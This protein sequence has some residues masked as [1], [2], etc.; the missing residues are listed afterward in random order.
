MSL[1]ILRAA[2]R[3]ASP[4]KNGGG[5]TREIAA[6]PPGASLAHFTWRISTATVEAGGPFSTFPGVDRTLAILSGSLDLRIEG[7][8]LVTLNPD[9]PPLPFAGDIPVAADPPAEPVLDLNVMVRRGLVR[10][11]VSRLR[12]QAPYRGEPAHPTVILARGDDVRLDGVHRLMRDD[13]ALIE[14]EAFELTGPSGAEV[15]VID[16]VPF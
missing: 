7:M 16:I 10:A 5:V 11:H 9:T 1:A 6:D 12:L 2:E 3:R 4:W 15:F 13:A 14:D 8:C